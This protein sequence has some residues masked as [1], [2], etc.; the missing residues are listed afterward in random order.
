LLKYTQ[1]IFQITPDTVAQKNAGFQD[2][3]PSKNEGDPNPRHEVKTS[4]TFLTR[5]RESPVHFNPQPL[6]PVHDEWQ[7]LALSLSLLAIAFVRITGKNFF[8]NIQSGFV[9]RPIFNQ[10]FRDGLLI[11][12]QARPVLLIS[13]ATVFTV[14][15]FQ[16]NQRYPFLAFTAHSSETINILKVFLLL[17]VWEITRFLTINLLGFVF[18]TGMIARTY[19]ATHIFYNSIATFLLLPLL[20]FSI[21]STTPIILWIAIGSYILLFVIR[22]FRSL[23]LASELKS[24]SFYQIILYLCTLEIVPVFILIKI[25]T[26][27]I[28]MI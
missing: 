15:L 10:L 18:K 16:I 11:P 21:Y 17:V 1:K 27:Y 25:L 20:L 9:S 4:E 7:I 5:E 14:L 8:K 24:Y 6:T 12:A 13:Y 26:D 19:I 28:S 22:F 23:L 2:A 3:A